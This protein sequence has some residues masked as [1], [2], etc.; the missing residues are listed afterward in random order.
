MLA[1]MRTRVLSASSGALLVAML[2]A[3]HSVAA[4]STSSGISIM[5]AEEA[6][7]ICGARLNAAIIGQCLIQ[8]YLDAP[9]RDAIATRAGGW[10][11]D[12]NVR[13][14]AVRSTGF[15]LFDGNEPV[16][17]TARRV[18]AEHGVGTEAT[19]AH[20][21][22]RAALEE[23]LRGVVRDGSWAASAPSANTCDLRAAA[24][25]TRLELEC[26]VRASSG[27]MTN[28]IVIIGV[29]ASGARVT[30]SQAPH[31][32]SMRRGGPV[33]IGAHGHVTLGE[34]TVAPSANASMRDEVTHVLR[35]NI[36]RVRACYERGLRTEPHAAGRIDVTFGLAANGHTV[37]EPTV[38]SSAAALGPRSD[39]ATCIVARIRSLD[40]PAPPH[41]PATVAAHFQ[42]APQP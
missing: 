37:G 16:R 25:A 1:P 15:A 20:V 3:S 34:L 13:A 32:L 8:P 21:P 11:A 42:L 5:S 38:V 9:T 27:E 2:T 40:F 17:A 12:P 35:A 7:T 19:L 6:H 10:L 28:G 23:L 29:D 22:T 33:P 18:L 14:I 41:A 39:I 26:T 24:D 31:P 30:S 36:G 4:Q